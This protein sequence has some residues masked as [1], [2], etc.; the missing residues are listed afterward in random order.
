MR[1]EQRLRDILQETRPS[2]AVSKETLRERL[3]VFSR[4]LMLEFD[5]GV[6]LFVVILEGGSRFACDLQT[7]IE[8]WF[9]F[10]VVS[11]RASSYRRSTIAGDLQMNLFDLEQTQD[12]VH[13]RDVVVIE[14]IID[15]GRTIKSVTEALLNFD[16]KTLQVATLINKLSR[17]SVEPDIC[18]KHVLFPELDGQFYV[19]YGMDFMQMF[20]AMNHISIL[21]DE[22]RREVEDWYEFEKLG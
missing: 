17:R 2:T 10:D 5:R 16:P 1:N 13:G 19:G 22:I 7:H 15:T 18:I 3:H 14:D 20:R 8:N 9:P 21:T 12:R 11:V 4:K 6:P